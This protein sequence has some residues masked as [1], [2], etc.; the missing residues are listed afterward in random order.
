MKRKVEEN[1]KYSALYLVFTG[2]FRV[3]S[4]KI[5]YLWDSVLLLYSTVNNVTTHGQVHS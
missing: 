3:I 1:Q 5:D 2:T 4:R